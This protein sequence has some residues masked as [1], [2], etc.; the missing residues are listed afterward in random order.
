MNIALLDDEETVLCQLKGYVDRYCAEKDVKADIYCFSDAV[1][2]LDH[3]R[4]IYDIVFLDIEMPYR[5]GMF[6]AEEI[7]K[8]DENVILIFVTNMAQY[9]VKGYSVHAYSFVVK[10]VDYAAFA[11]I[12][13]RALQAAGRNQSRES[14]LVKV[15]TAV[16]RVPVSDILYV[17]VYGHRITYHL[18]G[19]E[20]ACR[21]TMKAAEDKL[22][23]YGF[24][25]CHYC[26]LVNPA[27][28][29]AVDQA[30]CI[31]VNGETLPIAKARKDAF[32][33]DLAA[34]QCR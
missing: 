6:V 21:D 19:R 1:D 22:R 27:Y 10:P 7:R 28:V 26:Y 23:P 33:L 13:G 4:G 18:S 15:G 3:F 17:E 34:F 16:E 11:D 25:R 9:A 14:V 31:L 5:S 32:L 8:R 30:D 24:S 20:L 2:F 12:L 29:R